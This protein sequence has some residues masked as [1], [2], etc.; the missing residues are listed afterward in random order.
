MLAKHSKRIPYQPETITAPGET[1]AELLEE[2]G[3]TETELAQRMGRPV[4]TID[5]IIHGKA[6]LSQRQRFN[7]SRFFGVPAEYWLN[8]EAKYRASLLRQS[9]EAWYNR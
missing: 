1:V 5:E 3:M 8:H 6:P 4:K 7:W 9:E 2:R